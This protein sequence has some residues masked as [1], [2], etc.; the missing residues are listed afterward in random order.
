MASVN[1]RID[2]DLKHAAE[3]VFSYLGLNP[4]IAITLFYKQVV[5]TNSIPFELK[6]EMPNAETLQAI[7]EVNYMDMNPG[8]Y[9]TFH[10]VDDLMEDLMK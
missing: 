10:D 2:E 8:N 3:Q 5:R 7:K 6:A 4:T 9:K 1:V